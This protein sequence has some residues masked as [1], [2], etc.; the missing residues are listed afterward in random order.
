MGHFLRVKATVGLKYARNWNPRPKNPLIRHPKHQNRPIITNVIHIFF[1]INWEPFKMGRFFGEK[2]T[3]GLKYAQN[4][5]PRPKKPLIRHPKHQN[6]PIFNDFRRYRVSQFFFWNF[7]IPLTK[8]SLAPLVF[9]IQTCLRSFWKRLV[10]LLELVTGHL[11]KNAF[12][13]S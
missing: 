2:A 12:F 6:R 9:K 4:R 11:Q 10:I 7:H 5:N 8:I 13:F 3:I 1:F